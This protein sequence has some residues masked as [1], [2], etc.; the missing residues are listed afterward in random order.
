M[1]GEF[2]V[3][4]EQL[5]ASVEPFEAFVDE[6]GQFEPGVG[7]CTAQRFV[8]PAG[9]RD[10][11]QRGGLGDGGEH[12]P[13]AFPQGALVLPGRVQPQA[14]FGQLGGVA[15]FGDR[16]QP[17]PGDGGAGRAGEDPG[18]QRAFVESSG[19]AGQPDPPVRGQGHPGPAAADRAGGVDDDGVQDRGDGRD[20]GSSSGGPGVSGVSGVSGGGT[21]G[22][23][24]VLR[25]ML[26]AAV[27]IVHP[28]NP[29]VAYLR[30]R[31]RAEPS[32]GRPILPCARSRV[33]GLPPCVACGRPRGPVRL[34]VA[35]AWAVAMGEDKADPVRSA[36]PC[37]SL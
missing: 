9:R 25:L 4:G 16:L 29:F 35:A 32:P 34:R 3:L 14:Q 7:R 5:G 24:V 20:G 37:R 15:E 17:G 36:G 33:P 10:G 27:L 21:G 31:A 18:A 30:R 28:A 1:F 13:E 19:Q 26:V 22:G 2:D 6:V 11:A 23:A 8:A 12:Q